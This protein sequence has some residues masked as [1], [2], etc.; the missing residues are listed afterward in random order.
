VAHRRQDRRDAPGQHRLADAGR[1]DQ[2]EVVATGHRD[3]ERGPRRQLPADVDQI[4]AAG[5]RPGEPRPRAAQRR[6]GGDHRHHLGE[7]IGGQHLEALDHRGLSG[8]RPGHDHAAQPQVAGQDRGG[9]RA[10]HR[11]QRAVEAQLAE[12]HQAVDRRRIELALGDQH[13]DRDR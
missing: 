4:E 11:A 6:A 8:R 10:A 2:H 7:V 12:H 13:A 9:Q 3:L 5:A 1:A